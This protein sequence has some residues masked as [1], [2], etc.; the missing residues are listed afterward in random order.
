MD[1]QIVVALIGTSGGLMGLAG[2]WLGAHLNQKSSLQTALQLAEVERH[3]YARDR[4]WDARK[5]AYT[6]I[7][8]DLNFIYKTTDR[9]HDGF[10]GEM[11]EPERFF[12]DD[13]FSKLRDELWERF[14]SLNTTFE[15]SSLILSD[16]FKTLFQEWKS[17]FFNTDENDIPPEHYLQYYNSI[18]RYLPRIVEGAKAEI[19]PPGGIVSLRDRQ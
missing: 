16:S 17:D 3:K 14:R 12:N 1:T 19:A 6:T 18:S 4:L 15:D 7:I 2:T 10:Y 8:A 9:I 13:S 5:G 11:A